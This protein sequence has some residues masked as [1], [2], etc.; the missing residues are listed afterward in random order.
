MGSKK[1]DTNELIYRTKTDSTDF[2]K[3]MVNQGD[4]CDGG[5]MDQEFGIGI[6]TLRYTE[7]YIGDL[8]YSTENSTNIP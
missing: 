2:E 4:R 5:R 7:W 8:Q 1:K 3:L 6:C